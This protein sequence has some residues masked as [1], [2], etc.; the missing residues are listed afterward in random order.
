[1]GFGSKISIDLTLFTGDAEIN[2]VIYSSGVFNKYYL[3]NKVFYSF[4]YDQNKVPFMHF[5]VNA[6]KMFSI[7][8]IIC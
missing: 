5:T 4:N 8:L 6:K 3:A 1:M 7:W 2:P